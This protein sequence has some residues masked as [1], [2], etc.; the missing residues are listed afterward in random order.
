MIVQ[1]VA[2]FLNV[3]LP[4]LAVGTISIPIEDAVG[5]VAGLLGF[6]QHDAGAD[7]VQAAGRKIERLSG[8]DLDLAQDV[9]QRSVGNPALI[10][11]AIGIVRPPE[12]QLRARLRVED[13]PTLGLAERL[14]FDTLRVG[15]VGM[16]LHRE[17]ISCVDNFR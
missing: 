6:E 3:E 7:G 12:Y 14:M 9:S 13:E 4:R 1:N 2:G 8:L 17:P 15:I 16:D 10:F 5:E 11:G